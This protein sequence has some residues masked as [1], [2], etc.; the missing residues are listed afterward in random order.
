M[1]YDKIWDIHERFYCA[2]ERYHNIDAHIHDCIELIYVIKGRIRF[3]SNGK[4]YEIGGNQVMAISSYIPHSVDSTIT[5]GTFESILVMIPRRYILEYS[6]ILDGNSFAE[7]YFDDPDGSILRVFRLLRDIGGADRPRGA[8]APFS[9][10]DAFPGRRESAVNHTVLLLLSLVLSKC[11]LKP[12]PLST[13]HIVGAIEYITSNFRDE[14][15]VA[16]IAKAL[17]VNQQRLS[18]EFRE[19]M[20]MS[21]GK[22]ISR[23]RINEAARILLNDED[24]TVEVAAM[25]SGFGSTRSFLRDFRREKGCTPTEFRNRNKASD[26]D[27]NDIRS[28]EAQYK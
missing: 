27:K 1:F 23:L 4:S 12:K 24:A 26:R 28:R 14:L 11:G 8:D 22:Y 15:T 16:G 6:E 25:Q 19:V 17:L 10:L 7:P 5:D 18:S 3:T 21:I 20:G 13:I 9:F 2:A